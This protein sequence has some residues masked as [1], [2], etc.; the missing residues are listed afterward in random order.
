VPPVQ[1]TECRRAFY[2]GAWAMLMKFNSIGDNL[3]PEE[4]GVECLMR[5]EAELE[6]FNRHIGEGD[7]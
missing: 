2:A 6:E 1:W 5:A 4:V 3:V 7:L